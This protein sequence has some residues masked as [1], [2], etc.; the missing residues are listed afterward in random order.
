MMEKNVDLEVKALSPMTSAEADGRCEVRPWNRQYT[1][2]DSPFL[3]SIL[4][5]DEELLAAPMRLVG[6]ENG[7]ELVVQNV[8]SHLIHGYEGGKEVKACQYMQSSR[9]IYNTS[10]SAEYDGLMDWHL[11]IASHG[12]SVAQVFGLNACDTDPRELTRLWLEIPLK[13]SAALSYQYAPQAKI[14]ID[15]EVPNMPMELYAAGAMP[16]KSLTLPF[17]QQLFV[18]NDRAGFSLF[19]ETNKH[20]Q[21]ADAARVIECLVEEDAVVIRVHLLDSE[22][23]SWLNKGDGNGLHLFP[24]SFRIGMQVTPIKPFPKQP[25]AEKNMHIDCFKK[26][27]VNYEDFLFTN[28][29]ETPEI[30]I[31]RIARLGVNTLYIHEKWNDMQNSPM[32][33]TTAAKRLRL[34]VDEAHKRG[35]KVIPYFGYELSTLSPIYGKKSEEYLYSDITGHW[36]RY[37]WQ[38]AMQVCYNSNWQEDFIAGIERLYDEFGFD[39]LYLD[40]IMTSRGCRNEK[41]GCGYRDE[42]GKLHMTYPVFAIRN[43]MRRLCALVEKRGG[44]ICSHSY[45]TFPVATMAFSHV[46]WEGESV[47]SHFMKGALERVPEDYYRAIY[48]GRN[49]GVLVNMLCYSNPPIWTFREAMSNALPYGIIPKPVD[50]GSPLEDMSALWQILDAFP[51]EGAEWKPYFE[52]GATASDE[53]LRVSYYETEDEM[54]VFVANMYKAPI[55]GATVTLPITPKKIEDAE[56]GNLLAEGNAS[57]TLDVAS[58]DHRILRVTK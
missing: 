1:L 21:P 12:R 16:K 53:N 10:L 30:A 50:T 36:Y 3:S 47:Q 28:F 18:G 56:G 23:K 4:S 35:M 19:F 39:G 44:I 37:P 17:V 7:R 55:T 54:L 58:F 33:T 29:E 22:P 34:I 31:D 11:T 24:I 9:F 38:R 27:P 48:T 51:V 13:K 41:H 42:E 26:I 15:G 57:V 46:I 40:S 8:A 6:I 2:S 20:W 32:L 43:L 14:R 25:Y 52:N 5:G 45:G 49:L